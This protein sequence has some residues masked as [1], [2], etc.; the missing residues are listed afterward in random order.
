MRKE[1]I[2]S[3]IL[4]IVLLVSGCVAGN[5]PPAPSAT[6]TPTPT[7]I[8]TPTPTPVIYISGIVV[9][10]NGT[11]VADALVG[12]WQGDEFVQ[13]PENRQHTDATGSFNFTNLQ[14]AHYQVTADVGKHHGYVD[15]RFGESA[16]IVVALP[17]YGVSTASVSPGQISIAPGMPRFSVARTNSTTV[18]VHLDGF[19]GVRSLKGFYVK[20]PVI[21][22]QEV[23]PVD[24]PLGE[25]ETIE[26]T[27][28]NLTGSVHFVASSWVNGNYA[29]VVDTMV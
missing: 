10:K 18:V 13:T 28:P 3:G 11:P 9:D 21:T 8:P 19:G 27:D 6:A 7:P 25:G 23:V 2:L 14:P 26:I 17:D 12:L 24:T 29:V 4:A 1:L 22:T 5:P 16:N 15:R 20:S